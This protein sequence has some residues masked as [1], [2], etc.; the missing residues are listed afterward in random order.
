MRRESIAFLTAVLALVGIG[1]FM[2]YSA[3]AVESDPTGRLYR[4]LINVA[5]GAVAMWIGINL[6]Y[7]RFKDPIL[8][9]VI[10]A[11]VLVLLLLVLIPGIGVVRGGARRW[12]EI[13]G[14]SFQPS[15]MAKFAVILLLA[16][17]LSANQEK[18]EE[19]WRGLVPPL[20]VALFVAG[21][22]VL[23]RDLGT[24]LVIAGVAYIMMLLAGVRI[25]H[26]LP[27]LIPV[28]AGVAVLVITSP[29]RIKRIT[30]FLNPWDYRDD[31]AYQLIQSLAGFA[32]GSAWGQGLGAGEQ[33]LYYLPFAHTDFIFSVWAEETGLA[34]TLTLVLLF[35]TVLALGA[36]IAWRAP[37]L[38]GMLLA[39]GIVGL[40]ALQSAVNMGVT[41]G[42]LP[43][44]G[45]PLP[46]ISWGGSALIVCMGL[47]GIVINIGLQA[48]PAPRK[49]ASA[50]AH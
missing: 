36:L 27:T 7:H 18:I 37:D 10:V 32:R 30:S 25:R 41:T 12:I 13:A 19:F 23:E 17:K 16:V 43:T 49:L 1:V 20:L 29:H 21:L 46:F 22:V 38:F 11:F 35:T 2:V 3:S 39:G 9:R 34:G 6:D 45:L 15:E 8:F 44:K 50:P 48:Q 33:K 14:F 42:L 24:P 4:Q 26:I 40:V 31:E 28:A 5:I 47:M